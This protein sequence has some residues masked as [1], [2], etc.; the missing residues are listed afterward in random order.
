MIFR[1]NFI[2]KMSL[3]VLNVFTMFQFEVC[4]SKIVLIFISM[5]CS[6]ETPLHPSSPTTDI[7]WEAISS[8]FIFLMFLASVTST[9]QGMAW[10]ITISGLRDAVL[11]SFILDNNDLLVIP[12]ALWEYAG[13]APICWIFLVKDSRQNGQWLS[14]ASFTRS[15]ALQVSLESTSHDYHHIMDLSAL[16]VFIWPITCYT[17]VNLTWYWWWRWASHRW[18]KCN[19]FVVCGW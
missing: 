8:S 10:F 1:S 12:G 16:F 11:V 5:L 7:I 4:Q 14:P 13:W 17:A 6:V 15:T 19:R 3:F 9:H 2:K 18:L